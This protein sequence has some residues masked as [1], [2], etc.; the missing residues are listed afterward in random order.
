MHSP[1]SI[2]IVISNIDEELRSKAQICSVGSSGNLSCLSSS[3]KGNKLTAKSNYFGNF[4][5]IIDSVAPAL[6]IKS[7]HY[8]MSQDS[9]MSFEVD[10]ALSGVFSYNAYVDDAWVLLEYDP[11]NNYLTHYFDQKIGLG[12]HHLEIVVLD[13]VNNENRLQLEFVR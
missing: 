2:G 13:A 5:A 8:D 11:K 12:K 9:L 6:K 3:W 7:F 10:D 4:T 1:I